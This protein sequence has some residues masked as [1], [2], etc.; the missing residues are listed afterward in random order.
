AIARAPDRFEPQRRPIER[1]LRPST[2]LAA[3]AHSEKGRAGNVRRR[4]KDTRP[5]RRRPAQAARAG[6][7]SEI[8]ARA[9]ANEGRGS[10]DLPFSLV[11]VFLYLLPVLFAASICF[12]NPRARLSL[13]LS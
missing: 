7:E 2:L 12:S 6:P 3:L 9:A 10:S 11:P 13:G 5:A 1:W 8:P 4:E